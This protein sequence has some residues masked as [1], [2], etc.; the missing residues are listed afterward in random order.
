MRASIVCEW[1]L[2]LM[3]STVTVLVT[4]STI[5][6]VCKGEE[7]RQHTMPNDSLR[8]ELKAEQQNGKELLHITLVNT[9]AEPIIVERQLS[10]GVRIGAKDDHG[11]PA[12]LRL[13][14]PGDADFRWTP[15]EWNERM[16]SLRPG[17]SV[18]RVVDLFGGYMAYAVSMHGVVR[19]KDCIDKDALDRQGR[20]L[21]YVRVYYTM[22]RWG[23]STYASSTSG[24]LTR[25]VTATEPALREPSIG[26]AARTLDLK[27]GKMMD[28]DGNYKAIYS[29]AHFAPQ[30]K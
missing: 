25:D 17:E 23:V 19:F 22:T 15:K 4:G 29:S 5:A 1:P 27:T 6:L 2:G 21:R 3:W 20:Q 26:A 8:L 13:L 12:F 18:T 24:M 14:D 28:D 10:L 11:D 16:V 30:E 9:G 7:T